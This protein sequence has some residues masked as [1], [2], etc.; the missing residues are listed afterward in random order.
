MC[1]CCSCRRALSSASAARWARRRATFWEPVLCWRLGSRIHIE[2]APSTVPRA[3]SG[4]TIT[5]EGRV[6]LIRS[7]SGRWWPK[8]SSIS[9]D[10][11][12]CEHHLAGP[13]R[14]GRRMVAVRV[15]RVPVSHRPEGGLQ[16]RIAGHGGAAHDRAVAAAEVDGGG[17]GQVGHGEPGDV[18]DAIARVPAL[19]QQQTGLGEQVGAVPLAGQAHPQAGDPDRDDGAGQHHQQ[20]ARS[21][22]R[23]RCSRSRGRR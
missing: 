4:T 8:V 22:R 17:V 15:D 3:F 12:L 14:H 13:D 10:R 18:L 1:A 5:D 16:L 7:S 9:S 2:S 19:L 20:S 23:L 6:R 21:S 11:E